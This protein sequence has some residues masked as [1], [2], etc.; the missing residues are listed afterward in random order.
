VVVDHRR[1]LVGVVAGSHLIGHASTA[2]ATSDAAREVA[3]SLRRRL[4]GPEVSA[5]ALRERSWWSG[6]EVYVLVDDY[7]LAVPVAGAPHPLLPLVEFLPQAKDVGL[8]VVVARRCGGASR[9]LF[10]PFL[11]RLRELG[12]PGLVM[13]GSPDEGILLESIKPRP[14][15]PGRATLVDRRNGPR[16]IQLAWLPPDVDEGS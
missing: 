2:Q 4:P 1:T 10:D 13:N 6:P 7:D 16:R 14:L 12:T 9:A 5:R 15:P 3:E 8:H 11:S